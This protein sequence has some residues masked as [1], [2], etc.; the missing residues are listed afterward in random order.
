MFLLEFF[1]PCAANVS[2]G[3]PICSAIKDVILSLGFGYKYGARP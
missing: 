1:L 3:F 2:D